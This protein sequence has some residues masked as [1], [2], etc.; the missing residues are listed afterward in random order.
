MIEVSNY[1]KTKDWK[2]IAIEPSEESPMQN[3]RFGE[4]AIDEEKKT[5]YV[6]EIFLTEMGL[7]SIQEA[8]NRYF[9][10]RN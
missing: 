5:F 7:D 10:N 2:L 1:I 4:V 6:H 8:C 3:H 9:S